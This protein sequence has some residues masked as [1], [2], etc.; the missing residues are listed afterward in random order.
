M[1]CTEILV[2]SVL[3]WSHVT[4]LVRNIVLLNSISLYESLSKNNLILRLKK[5]ISFNGFSRSKII[6]VN[7][8][9]VIFYNDSYSKLIKYIR[10]SSLTW[11]L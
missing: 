10:A 7:N 11:T 6:L 4:D 3:G 8:I 5:M 1:E 2:Q 9:N